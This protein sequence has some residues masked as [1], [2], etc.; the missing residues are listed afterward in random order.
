[1]NE[2]TKVSRRE[3]SR[4]PLCFVFLFGAVCTTIAANGDGSSEVPPTTTPNARY[5]QL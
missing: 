2:A 3:T 4:R 5:Q 1:M